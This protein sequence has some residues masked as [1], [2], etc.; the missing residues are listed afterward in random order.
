MTYD[1]QFSL[2]ANTLPERLAIEKRGYVCCSGGCPDEC[3]VH[4][5]FRCSV[6][7]FRVPWSYGCDSCM[8][9]ACDHCWAHAH[10]NRHRLY[11]AKR[12]GGSLP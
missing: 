3:S 5:N 2:E 4:E 9:S 8:P 10:A 7:G 11:R 12:R 1:H 6:C